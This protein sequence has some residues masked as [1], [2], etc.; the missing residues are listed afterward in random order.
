MNEWISLSLL[1]EDKFGVYNLNT[2][3][4]LDKDEKTNY[5]F[6]TFLY[7]LNDQLFII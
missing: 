4:Y 5:H 1:F 6:L 7:P 3:R 2:E